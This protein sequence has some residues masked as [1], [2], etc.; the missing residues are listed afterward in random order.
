MRSMILVVSVLALVGCSKKKSD[1]GGEKVTKP[2]TGSQDGSGSAMKPD[3]PPKPA[4]KPAPAITQADVVAA[5]PKWTIEAMD[6]GLWFSDNGQP[7]VQ[8]CRVEL[9]MAMG[10]MGKYRAAA[11]KAGADATKCEAKG[12]YTVCTFTNPDKAAPEQQ[13]TWIFGNDD[14][15]DGVVLLAT[16]LGP[17]GD[18]AAIEPQLGEKKPCP[19]PS[20]DPQ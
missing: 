16:V 19:K 15:S 20:D 13:A 5:E 3:E 17:L 1:G 12:A 14:D 10:N 4:A 2:E 8:K 7:L 9:G 6:R 18:W 11:E